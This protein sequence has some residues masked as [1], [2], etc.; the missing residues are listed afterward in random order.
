MLEHFF[1]KNKIF[2]EKT[3]HFEYAAS[4][5][6]QEYS[7]AINILFI[8]YLCFLIGYFFT[9]YFLKNFKRKNL[10]YLTCQITRSCYW[11]INLMS[12]IFFFYLLKIQNYFIFLSQIKFLL[13]LFGIGLTNHYL[14]CK[15]NINK[16]NFVILILI[17]A[18]PIILELITGSLNFP[19]MIIFLVYIYYLVLRKRINL[20]PFF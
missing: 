18:T 17:I 7:Y 9:N 14:I 4:Y 10:D 6:V 12:T 3:T 8:G 15:K 11:F 13:L 2:I 19:F 5:S 16:F 20:L 1:N